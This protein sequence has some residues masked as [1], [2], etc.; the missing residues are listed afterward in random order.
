[1]LQKF[2]LLQGAFGVFR[3]GTNKMADRLRRETAEDAGRRWTKAA[4]REP[5][6]RNDLVELGGLLRGAPVSM[7]D[8]A[9]I[10]PGRKD[11]YQCGVEEGRRALALELLALASLTHEDFLELTEGD[12]DEN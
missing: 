3:G 11:L 4:A 12:D 8:G 1:M 5:M 7:S 10:G 2:S 6:L 9:V